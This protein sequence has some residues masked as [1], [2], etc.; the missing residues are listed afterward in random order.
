MFIVLIALLSTFP[1]PWTLRLLF[2]LRLFFSSLSKPQWTHTGTLNGSQW[3]T[4]TQPWSPFRSQVPFAS[5]LWW[6]K[7]SYRLPLSECD[8]VIVIVLM[9][10]NVPGKKAKKEVCHGLPREGLYIAT[11]GY[12]PGAAAFVA[13]LLLLWASAALPP[14]C[15]EFWEFL[16][17]IPAVLRTFPN[18]PTCKM[19]L[20]AMP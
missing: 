8:W 14:N 18:Y 20:Y 2:F 6:Q 15:R 12:V 7:T 1:C 5:L 13:T 9:D 4:S 17:W 3:P 11:C 16:P 19:H 10:S